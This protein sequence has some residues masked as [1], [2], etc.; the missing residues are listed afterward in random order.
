M[1]GG[2]LDEKPW[3]LT[4]LERIFWDAFPYMPVKGFKTGTD[5]C[6]RKRIAFSCIIF[7]F[8]ANALRFS[9]KKQCIFEFLTI[10]GHF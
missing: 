10:L 2:F 8:R 9:D 7:L 5:A 3:L 1:V 4:F 6:D